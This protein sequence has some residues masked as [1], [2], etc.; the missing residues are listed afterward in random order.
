M[1]G[2]ENIDLKSLCKVMRKI[3][4]FSYLMGKF[5]CSHLVVRDF[6]G[7]LPGCRL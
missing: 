6:G 7:L 5:S 4:G 3:Q 1:F 2:D